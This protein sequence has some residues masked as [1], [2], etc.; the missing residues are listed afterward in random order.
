MLVWRCTCECAWA[1]SVIKWWNM[2]CILRATWQVQ[3]TYR[4][5]ASSFDWCLFG[6]RAQS[7][8]SEHAWIIFGRCSIRDIALQKKSS[9]SLHREANT[10]CHEARITLKVFARINCFA[11]V[12]LSSSVFSFFIIT[13]EHAIAM[14]MHWVSINA[15]SYTEAPF[16]INHAQKSA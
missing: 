16:P 14:W 4:I 9:F 15:C 5:D 6:G 1:C 10:W 8:L 11:N 12:F 3:S 13:L 2:L 7:F